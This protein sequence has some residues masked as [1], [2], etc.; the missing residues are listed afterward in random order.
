MNRYKMA[1]QWL[2]LPKPLKESKN[3]GYEVIRN[4]RKLIQNDQVRT[5]ISD[6]LHD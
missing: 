3:E 5:R 6:R 1:G 4:D 2:S